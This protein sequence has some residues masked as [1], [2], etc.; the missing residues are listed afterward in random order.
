MAMRWD[1]FA[2]LVTLRE[3]M[4]NLF[5]QSFVG[6]RRPA[7]AEGA[8]ERAMPIDLCEREGDY[9]IKAYVPGVKAEDV[10]LN[11]DQNTLTI[12]THIPGDAES[13]E[14]K[15]YKWLTRELGYGD[16]SR[17]INLPNPIDADKV[18]ATVENGVLTVTVPK[19]EEVRP[20]KIEVKGK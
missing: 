8:G 20:K 19:A 9:V 1:P 3:A 13:E 2:D 17:S 5:D 6:P 14:A 11:V 16:I 15:N 18:E 10:N 12:K 4:D 7:L